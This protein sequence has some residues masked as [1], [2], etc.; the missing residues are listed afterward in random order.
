MA[1]PK[2]RIH[3]VINPASG[4]DEPILN[5]INDVFHQHDIDWT[6]SVTHK[7][8]D[9]TAFAKKAVAEGYD[10][11]AGYGGDGTQMEV[12]N[13]LMGSDIPLAI[14]PGGTGNAMAWEL[15]VPRD[16]RQAAQLIIDSQKRRAIDLA[17]IGDRVFMLRTYTG[18]QAEDA[19]SREAK[20]KHGNM[21]YVAEGLKVLIN[22]PH[23][24]YHA[25]IDDK[26]FDG[27]AMICY[28]F[29]AGSIGGI[30]LPEISDVD[31][32]DGLLDLF[33]ITKNVKPLRAVSHYLLNIGN[34]EAGVHHWQGRE[35]TLAADP[36]QTVW[37]DGEAYGQ[38]PITAQVIPQA[39]RV[40]VP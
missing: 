22:L 21:A 24:H 37:I 25:T 28:I 39:L 5:V 36:P 20:D 19:A 6:V 2:K 16:L 13:G 7:F 15:K 11:V 8:G 23:A 38:T 31:V 14:L 29:N 9:A 3:V 18:V 34:A 33:V 4:K 17:R 12:A 26:V 35:I 30:D 27:S 10:I 1:D 32:S 40:I